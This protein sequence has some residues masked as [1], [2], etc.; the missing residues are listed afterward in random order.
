MESCLVLSLV[1]AGFRKGL[2]AI[3]SPIS[4]GRNGQL[5]RGKLLSLIWH[6]RDKIRQFSM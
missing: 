1:F 6:I 4:M 3:K 5:K 2:S